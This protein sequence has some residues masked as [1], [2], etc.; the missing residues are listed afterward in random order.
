MALACLIVGASVHISQRRLRLHLAHGIRPD[1]W[2]RVHIRQTKEHTMYAFMNACVVISVF[3][4]GEA[5][6]SRM[7]MACSITSPGPSC[8]Q[9]LMSFAFLKPF[10][11]SHDHKHRK[12]GGLLTKGIGF[13][14][15]MM[16]E[17]IHQALDAED[18]RGIAMSAL[19][20]YG[21]RDKA[22]G[23]L[24]LWCSAVTRLIPANSSM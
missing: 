24:P 16:S 7:K 15:T 11:C 23:G 5:S 22:S 21:H 3:L 19:E 6:V 1:A 2:T 17:V 10:R 9:V 12:C 14:P 13:Y 20:T 18:G 4:K 8:L